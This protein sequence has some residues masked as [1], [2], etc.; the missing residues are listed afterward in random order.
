MKYYLKYTINLNKSKNV[1]WEFKT[2]YNIKNIKFIK[3][4]KKIKMLC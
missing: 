1:S 3:K 2:L 4:N